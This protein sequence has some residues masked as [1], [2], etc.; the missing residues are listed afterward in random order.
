MKCR[1]IYWHAQEKS[2]LCKS[3]SIKILCR[4]FSRTPTDQLQYLGTSCKHVFC[5][6]CIRSFDGMNYSEILCP[7]CLYPVETGA[8]KI[9]KSN[10]FA[11]LSNNIDRFVNLLQ[12]VRFFWLLMNVSLIFLK[13]KRS[14]HSKQGYRVRCWK[15]R[16]NAKWMIFSHFFL[17]SPITSEKG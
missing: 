2:Y 16:F 17:L 14:G 13:L 1:E 4:D 5:W 12:E 8:G 15:D 11:N 6:D 9:V 3:L 7:S 10:L